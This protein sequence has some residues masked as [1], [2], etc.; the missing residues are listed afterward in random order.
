MWPRP[1]RRARTSNYCEKKRTYSCS[2][3][4]TL[5]TGMRRRWRCRCAATQ[6]CKGSRQCSGWLPSCHSRL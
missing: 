1:A 5:E 4:Q 2:C 3:I 6:G